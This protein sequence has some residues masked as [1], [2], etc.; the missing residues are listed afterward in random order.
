MDFRLYL[1][2][3]D[4]DAFVREIDATKSTDAMLV[5][6]DWL[7]EKGHDAT[8][9]RGV[10]ED[11]DKADFV[12]HYLH[13]RHDGPK[14]TAKDAK[15]GRIHSLSGLYEISGT[16]KMLSSDFTNFNF[17]KWIEDGTQPY[18]TTHMTIPPMRPW[19]RIDYFLKKKN[20]ELLEHFERVIVANWVENQTKKF[21][22]Q[23]VG[24]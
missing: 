18:A 3:T 10:L 21:L 14:V 8:F 22:R 24:L 23:G 20:G 7:E 16:K 19:M 15:T 2:N 13:S 1:E 4:Y 5:F 17:G 12:S 6:C 9:I 11:P